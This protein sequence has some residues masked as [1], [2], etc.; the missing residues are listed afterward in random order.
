[1]WDDQSSIFY[2]EGDQMSMYELFCVSP[3]RFIPRGENRLLHLTIESG[4]RDLVRRSSE[5]V[6]DRDGIVR[7]FYFIRS[8]LKL[9]YILSNSAYGK[10]EYGS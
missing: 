4:I 9:P 1:M 5:F 6:L 3:P 10:M 2:R 8:S 7:R